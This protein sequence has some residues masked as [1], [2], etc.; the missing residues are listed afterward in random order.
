VSAVLDAGPSIHLDM[1]EDDY[2]ADRDSLSS[3]GARKLLAC[4]AL[5]HHER[6]HGRPSRDVLDFGHAAHRLI[7][8]AGNDLAVIDAADWRTKAAQQA[9]DEAR[10]N[11]QVPILVGD[12][13]K[14]QE[15]SEAISAH[16]IASALIDHDRGRPEV[17]LFWPD[18]RTGVT[19]R[20]RID[21]LPDPI[22]GRRL[23]ATDYKTT[24]SADPG[25]LTRSVAAFGYHQQAAWYLEGIR[26]CGIADDA[27]FVFVAQEKTPPYLVTVFELDAEALRIGASLNDRALALYAECTATDHWPAY[28]DDVVTVSLPMWAVRQ[29]EETL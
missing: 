9:R 27:A 28:S 13:A 21:W 17:S 20:A 8:G 6:E 25:A 16:P 19:R 4:P 7:L 1:P 15:M 23:I 18:A 3:S 24:A 11:G 10:E 2:H 22:E 14:A 12:Y 5:F 26:A 29:H